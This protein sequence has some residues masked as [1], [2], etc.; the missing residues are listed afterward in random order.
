M[1]LHAPRAHVVVGKDATLAVGRRNVLRFEGDS[2]DFVRE[3]LAI[4]RSPTSIDDAEAQLIERYGGAPVRDLLDD[5]LERL[6]DAEVV[7]TAS[8]AV[9]PF[10]EEKRSCLSGSRV[11][12][13]VGGAIAAAHAPLTVELLQRRG[14]TVRVVLGSNASQFVSR[15]VLE[16]LTHHP[17]ASAMWGHDVATT[18]APVPHL[19]L[20]RWGELVVWAPASASGIAAVAHGD[21][22]TLLAATALSTAAPVFVAPMMNPAMR[23]APSVVRNIET[24]LDDGFWIMEADHGVEVADA[25]DARP[26]PIRATHTPHTLV[27]AIEGA[28][29]LLA[30][31]SADWDRA[32]RESDGKPSF[33]HEGIEPAVLAEIVALVPPSARVLDVGAGV[34]AQARA[35]AE[36]GYHVVAIEPSVEAS[37]RFDAEANPL[38]L[39]LETDLETFRC[40]TK[41]DLIFD[42]GT[43]HSMT[44][45]QRSMYV[46]RACALSRPG[47]IIAITHDA[48][49]APPARTERLSPQ[50]VVAEFEGFTLVKARPTTLRGA[51]WLTLL[52]RNAPFREA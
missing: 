46:E 24:L 27:A 2:S 33:H 34:G 29:T 22:T 40:S 21:F 5:V 19:A 36:A 12:L 45:A 30:S 18:D 10:E 52:R 42:R 3:V 35:L 6:K 32:Y 43:F 38:V 14:A 16:A 26:L 15:R 7:E 41:F 17:V 20:A 39:Y 28:W 1:K 31:A 11:L 8:E 51:A 9:S 23:R 47:T 25:P 13:L 44:R 48:E 49:S 4:F 50:E 37:R